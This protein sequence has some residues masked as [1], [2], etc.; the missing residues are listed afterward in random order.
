M[1][2][3]IPGPTEVHPDVF[4]AMTHPQ[5]GH[6]TPPLHDLVARVTPKLRR[7]FGTAGDAFTSTSSASAVL[8]ATVRNLVRKRALAL[9]CG[10][11]SERW[12]VMAERNGVAVDRLSVPLGRVHDPADVS[13]A[14][15]DGRYDAV[16]M[17]WC[18]TST[19]VLEPL[20]DLVAA[21][22]AHDDVMVCVDAVSALGGVELDVDRLGVDVCVAGVQKAM[23]MPPGLAVFTV[24]ER[25]LARAR[26]IDARGY[27]V[28][29]V[30][31][32]ENLARDETPTTPSTAHLYALDVALD[33]IETEGMPARA[34]RHRAMSERCREWAADRFGLFGD[35]AAA[36]PTVTCLSN[37]DGVDLAGFLAAVRSRGY[38][39]GGGFGEL[40]GRTFRVGHMGEHTLD[41]VEALLAAMDD[42][43]R[44]GA[45]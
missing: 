43:R 45:A 30:A 32:H 41:D 11:W 8:E 31:F 36:S 1:R 33:R 22:R 21:V 40:K 12:A 6:R 24:S 13:K 9:V 14:L 16:L 26:T 4:A 20:A 44:S 7:L 38:W 19:G 27:F 5:I 35:P 29:F 2:L 25:A 42:A 15:A 23:A 18:E 10:E 28:D 3:F 17:V 34:A 39:L 37:P